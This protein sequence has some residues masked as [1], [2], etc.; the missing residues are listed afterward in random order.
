MNISVGAASESLN[1]PR[2]DNTHRRRRH[3][4][5]R[6]RKT[7]VESTCST[8]SNYYRM[9][10]TSFS[11]GFGRRTV[12]QCAAIYFLMWFRDVHSH[13]FC[14]HMWIDTRERNQKKNRLS[15]VI[16]CSVHS[17]FSES[18]LLHHCNSNLL[19]PG[20][21]STTIRLVHIRSNATTPCLYIYAVYAFAWTLSDLHVSSLRIFTLRHYTVL[22]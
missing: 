7:D 15:I 1:I 18:R 20:N 8:Y 21:G 10:T 17:R 2:E 3:T 13:L 11:E 4:R 6:V 16:I 12:L 9:L 22:V 19:T 14:T 5:S